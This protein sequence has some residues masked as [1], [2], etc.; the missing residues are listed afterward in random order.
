MPKPRPKPK[1][2]IKEKIQIAKPA[3]P[4]ANPR[5]QTL[6][7]FVSRDKY[8]SVKKSLEKCCE[9]YNVTL[10][11]IWAVADHLIAVLD[12]REREVNYAA[13]TEANGSNPG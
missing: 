7:Q 11:Q 5:E 2:R 12:G 3:I 10:R 9:S 13:A 6:K 4:K 1:L 8:A